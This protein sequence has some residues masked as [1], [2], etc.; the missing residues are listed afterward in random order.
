MNEIVED[1]MGK[2]GFV[3]WTGV[4]EELSD[5]LK[6]GRVRVRIFGFHSP[7]KTVLPTENLPWAIP[8]QPITSAAISGVGTSPTGLVAGSWV[9]GFFRDGRNAQDPVVMGSFAGIPQD[10]SDPNEGFNDPN[11]KYPT[12]EYI[13]ESDVN[14]LA[15]GQQ[16]TNTIVDA[17][18]QSRVQGVRTAMGG[19]WSEPSSQYSAVYP[20]NNVTVS[21][22][23]HVV[24]IDDTSAAPRIHIYHNSG[25]F[26]EMYPD[27]SV[28]DKVVGDDYEIDLRNKKIIVK[29]NATETTDGNK[30][31]LVGGG[32]SVEVIG[33]LTTYVHGDHYVH[34]KGNFYHKVDGTYTVVSVGK[35]LQVAPRIDFNPI[36]LAPEIF[37]TM[38]LLKDVPPSTISTVSTRGN[39]PEIPLP[40]QPL[41]LFNAQKF[42]TQVATLEKQ[43][44]TDRRTASQARKSADITSVLPPSPDVSIGSSL[45]KAEIIS[46]ITQSPEEILPQEK[47][48]DE[49]CSGISQNAEQY[50]ACLGECEKYNES[51]SAPSIPE[52]GKNADCDLLD[53]I[54]V[55]G[56][57]GPLGEAI[58]DVQNAINEVVQG[59]QDAV[60][61][62]VEGVQDAAEGAV[63]DLLGGSKTFC[64][65]KLTK[66]ASKAYESFVQTGVGPPEPKKEFIK[67]YLNEKRE[68][69]MS[70]LEECQEWCKENPE[71]FREEF[72]Q[73]IS[74]EVGIAVPS[75]PTLPDL[76]LSISLNIPLP[77]LPSIPCL[78]IGIASI[79]GIAAGIG[80]GIAVAQG[81]GGVG[82]VAAGLVTGAVAGVTVTSAVSTLI[83]PEVVTIEPPPPLP[84]DTISDAGLF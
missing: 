57:L 76:G 1:F 65:K 83:S 59:V 72:S 56:L 15:R 8:L 75:L 30:R 46:Q 11:G 53:G 63:Q 5:P 19:S 78:G 12:Q 6:I 80:T 69:G 47:N 26:L 49:Y 52:T 48:C 43:K 74:E 16:T 2:N 24:E 50:E 45:N 9:M 31:V 29:G 60:N 10:V 54:N 33:N 7:D 32:F 36:G 13:G 34:T 79:A 44:A 18:R 73:Q 37:P 25:S 51:L 42:D 84:T 62:V 81:I 27:G 58:N 40:L 28:V 64:S 23:G 71:E 82:G 66:A 67:R 39:F 4:V 68:S 21:R 22:A 35:A 70:A 3:W 61:D 77:G 14:R 55:G 17:K 20:M 41:N 38:D